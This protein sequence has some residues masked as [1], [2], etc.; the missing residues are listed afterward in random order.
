[1][2]QYTRQDAK[3]MKKPIPCDMSYN[4]S[5]ADIFFQI[6]I[7]KHSIILQQHLHAFRI[8]LNQH[9][10]LLGEVKMYTIYFQTYT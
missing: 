6:F 1:M 9:L 5:K 10:W 3:E 8:L 4:P 2:Y 7:S